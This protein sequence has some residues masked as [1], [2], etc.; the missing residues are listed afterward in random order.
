[1][2][3]SF[4]P[5]IFHFQTPNY[6][7]FSNPSNQKEPRR[8]P[9]TTYAIRI[10]HYEIKPQ[11]PSIKFVVRACPEKGHEPR[12]SS[13]R[14]CAGGYKKQGQKARIF[15]NFY[16]FLPIFSLPGQETC[17]FDSKTSA[18]LKPPLK[19]H[20]ALQDKYLQKFLRKAA[21]NQTNIFDTFLTNTFSC[22][23]AWIFYFS[24][25]YFSPPSLVLVYSLCSV[26]SPRFIS[27]S[28]YF[29]LSPT[30]VSRETFCLN[31]LCLPNILAAQM[32]ILVLSKM[33]NRTLHNGC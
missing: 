16:D 31:N 9:L 27:F 4:L 30:L 5:H 13:T 32:T 10:T 28:F 7:K 19:E 22:P 17:A 12:A 20:K 14:I 6:P 15:A 23:A 29:C 2:R 24:P 1:M 21:K 33:R 25:F 3:T 26:R 18:L 11:F 8:V